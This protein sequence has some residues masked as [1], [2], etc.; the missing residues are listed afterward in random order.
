MDDDNTRAKNTCYLTPSGLHETQ[1]MQIAQSK[2]RKINV[3][4]EIIESY[5]HVSMLILIIH[6]Q[7]TCR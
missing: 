4:E 5:N 1:E 6:F 3:H 2:R 7:K